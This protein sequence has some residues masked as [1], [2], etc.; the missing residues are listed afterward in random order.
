MND[1]VILKRPVARIDLAACYAYISERNPV[2]ARRFLVAAEA[3]FTALARAG[4][5]CGVGVANTPCGDFVA[6][7]QAVQELLD[8]LLARRP[9][10]ELPSG[11]CYFA[12]TTPF[13]DTRICFALAASSSAYPARPSDR[14]ISA[15]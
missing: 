13:S 6:P 10:V 2:A 11:S 9:T 7:G 5:W 3:S 1:P 15:A 8:L 12:E 4:D 14:R